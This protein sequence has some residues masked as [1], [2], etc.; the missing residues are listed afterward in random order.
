M[1]KTLRS[2]SS[3]G[4]GSQQALRRNNMEL[5]ILRLSSEGPATQRKLAERTNLSPA[6]VSNLVGIL[7][8]QG[9]VQ[10]TFTTSSGRR[11]ILVSLS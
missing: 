11:A 3:Y 1:P 2:E 7:K 8:S 6:T 10:T 4:P 9:R 5:L